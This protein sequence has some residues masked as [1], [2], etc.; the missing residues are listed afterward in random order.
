MCPMR[1]SK[2][3]L[4]L[5]KNMYYGFYPLMDSSLAYRVEIKVIKRRLLH[6]HLNIM[7]L[8]KG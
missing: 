2:N 3:G 1:I 7:E 4:N 6:I 5:R 8:Q